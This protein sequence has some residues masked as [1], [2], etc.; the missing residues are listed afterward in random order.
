MLIAPERAGKEGYA[1]T[2]F[3]ALLA[4]EISVLADVG[5]RR[6]NVRQVSPRRA[7]QYRWEDFAMLLS[8]RKNCG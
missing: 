5:N 1:S 8:N 6:K 4:C 3:V 2:P 7:P